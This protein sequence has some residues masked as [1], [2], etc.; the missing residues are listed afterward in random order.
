MCDRKWWLDCEEREEER[1]CISLQQGAAAMDEFI[2]IVEC[3]YTQMQVFSFYVFPQY[4]AISKIQQNH[5]F[6]VE[7]TSYKS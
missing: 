2:Y 3:I 4:C 1:V 6:T 5:F 7:S